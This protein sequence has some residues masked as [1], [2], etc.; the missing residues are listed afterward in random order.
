[1]Q[2]RNWQDNSSGN[3]LSG[4]NSSSTSVE[5]KINEILPGEKGNFWKR[6]A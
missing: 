1:M 5:I 3:A 6:M 2:K 4:E